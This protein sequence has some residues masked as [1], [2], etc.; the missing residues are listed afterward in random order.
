[1]KTLIT[2]GTIAEEL[3]CPIWQVQYLLQSRGI[4]PVQRAGHVRVF[5]PAVVDT[6]RQELNSIQERRKRDRCV[7]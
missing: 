2:V 5:S 1:M 7:G 6:L 4:R 3:N